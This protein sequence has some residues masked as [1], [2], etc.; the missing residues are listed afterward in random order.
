MAQE[1]IS[2]RDVLIRVLASDKYPCYN[3]FDCQQAQR[4]EREALEMAD[5]AIP[6]PDDPPEFSHWL[7]MLRQPDL[8]TD[9]REAIYDAMYD[10]F[11]PE[12][13]PEKSR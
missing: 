11:E 7:E 5:N 13:T 4:L 1:Q 8:T 6:S 9:G 12:G 10:Y 2:I 3:A